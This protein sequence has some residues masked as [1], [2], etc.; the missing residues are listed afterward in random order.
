MWRAGADLAGR[1]ATG[2]ARGV[3]DIAVIEAE[4]RLGG[5]IQTERLDGFCC[6]L[7]P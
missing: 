1:R 2:R 5:K 3:G 7:G 4:E 6:E